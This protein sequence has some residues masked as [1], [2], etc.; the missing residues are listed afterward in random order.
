MKRI[1]EHLLLAGIVTIGGMLMTSCD[2]VGENDRYILT[3]AVSGERSILLED[4]T[5]QN[6]VNCPEAHE[7]IEQLQEQYGAD[8]V[9]AVSIHSGV[10]GISVS[11]T[12]FDKNVVGLMTDEGNKICN[13]YNINSFPMGVIDMGNPMVHS[14]WPS[15]VRTA[16]QKE[17][18]VGIDMKVSYVADPKDSPTAGYFGKIEVSADINSNADKA[19]NVQFWVIEDG[20]VAIQRT[21]TSV[22]TDYV[23]NNVF[24]AQMFE[25]MSGQPQNLQTGIKTTVTAE[26]M[27]RWSDT[28]R[29]NVNNLSIVAIVSDG[30][31]VLQAKEV[32][33]IDN[34]EEPAEDPNEEEK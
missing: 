26:I 7:V 33:V 25:E 10:F 19:V 28:E 32:K 2:E 27:N 29:W 23:H 14:L 1:Y 3:E 34:G 31:G 4:F 24:R 8:K 21:L 20:I 12:N 11:K 6:C 22:I 9:I 5:G 15:A 17:S 13:K 16:L 18:E 30:T